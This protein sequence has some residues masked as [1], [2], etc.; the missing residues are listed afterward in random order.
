MK[1]SAPDL[2]LLAAAALAV[3]LAV[4]A[5]DEPFNPDDP[6]DPPTGLVAVAASAHTISFAWDASAGADTYELY[7]DSSATGAFTI[8][9]Y[10]GA[11]RTCT[12]TGLARDTTYWFKVRAKGTG[13]TGV[14]SA[15]VQARTSD[16]TP[17]VPTDL[18]FTG[19]SATSLTLA[20]DAAVDAESY[21]LE[22]SLSESV[23]YVEAYAGPATAFEDVDLAEDT[24]YWYRVKAASEWGES[25]TS[26]PVAHTTGNVAGTITI[27]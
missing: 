11:A 2:T 18:R 25:V 22:R 7:R 5:C 20:W 24:L 12:A 21:V 6:P 27:H 16:G 10:A 17:P 23:G 8:R 4:M 26:A 15:A 9:A 1:R 19:A 14:F 13:G 3:A